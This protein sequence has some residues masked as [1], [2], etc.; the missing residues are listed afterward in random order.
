[1][2]KRTR[3]AGLLVGILLVSFIL[4]AAAE[5]GSSSISTVLLAVLAALMALTIL[6]R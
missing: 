4:Y 6:H 5:S 3:N 1:M 2:S